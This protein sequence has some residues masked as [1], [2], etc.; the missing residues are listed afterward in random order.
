[1]E[2][3]RE[4]GEGERERGGRGVEGKEEKYQVNE[5]TA[6]IDYFAV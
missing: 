4:G 1:M 6:A 3:G 2:G 5:C